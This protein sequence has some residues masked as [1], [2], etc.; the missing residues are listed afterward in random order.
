MTEVW[1]Y[2]TEDAS[3]PARALLLKRLLERARG[4][5]R[6]LYI[7]TTDAGAAEKLDAW[8]WQPPVAFL[9]HGRSG[10]PGAAQQPV[11]IGHGDDPGDHHDML[12]NLGDDVPD[13]FSRFQRVVELVGG[14]D[15]DRVISRERWKLYRSRGYQVTKH[16]LGQS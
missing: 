6:R 1:F 2:V 15:N 11:V 10:D 5:G 3:A 7:H 4:S 14:G 12:V 13:F 9:P 16:E 8:L